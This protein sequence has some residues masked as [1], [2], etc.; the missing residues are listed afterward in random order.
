MLIHQ[1]SPQKIEEYEL[2]TLTRH[3][4][5]P[6]QCTAPMPASWV[7]TGAIHSI[8]MAKSAVD[9]TTCRFAD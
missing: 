4:A 1:N 2:T 8:K 3:T 5:F 6:P 9:G 7:E